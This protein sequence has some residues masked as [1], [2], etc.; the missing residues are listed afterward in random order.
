V[1]KG[2]EGRWISNSFIWAYIGREHIRCK[3]FSSC[4]PCKLQSGSSDQRPHSLRVNHANFNLG[5]RINVQWEGAQG[6]GE[7][8]VGNE[9]VS[10]V[11]QVLH[12]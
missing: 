2:N 1:G 5:H 12:L 4:K 3:S 9:T 6:R 8:W 7:F 10:M 11:M